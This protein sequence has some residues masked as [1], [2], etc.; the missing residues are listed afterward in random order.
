[1]HGPLTAV[2][3]A[4]LVRQR[5]GRS[6]ASFSFRSVKPLFDLAPFRLMATPDG[7]TVACEALGPDGR[8]ALQAKAT[9]GD[10]V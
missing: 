8:V 4:D 2:L 5:S 10:G 3:L 6:I 7:D 1:V 9:L